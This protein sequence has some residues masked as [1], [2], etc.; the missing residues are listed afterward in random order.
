M[1]QIKK[2]IN[3]SDICAVNEV[4][5]VLPIKYFR[6]TLGSVVNRQVDGVHSFL[7]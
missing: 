7:E 5:N 2:K 6:L 3:K 4:V 1:K